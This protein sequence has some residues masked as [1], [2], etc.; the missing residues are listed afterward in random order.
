MPTEFQ[1]KYWNSLKGKPTWNKGLTGIYSPEVIE[2]NRLAHLGK[3]QSEETK[4]KMRKSWRNVPRMHG[5]H[6]SE[7]QK[8][9]VRKA[10][11]GNTRNLGRKNG[12]PSLETIEKIRKSNLGKIVSEKTIQKLKDSHLG[13]PNKSKGIKRPQ[14][15]GENHPNWIKDRSLLKISENKADDYKYSIWSKEVKN[16]DCWKC[17]I[18]NKDCKGRLESHHILNWRDFPELRYEVNNGITLCLVHHPRKRIEE[19]R[20]I[21][22]FKK[23]VEVKE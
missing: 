16:R 8:E 22:F 1:I 23:M 14:C 7:Y 5:K 18:N 13:I 2:K 3:K 9:C 4:E 20:L 10:N 21:P 19:K 15:S 6:Q 11:L 12:H 17:K